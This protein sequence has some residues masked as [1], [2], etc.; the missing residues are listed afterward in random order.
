MRIKIYKLKKIDVCTCAAFAPQIF[1]FF[2][3]SLPPPYPKHNTNKCKFKKRKG[4]KKEISR[5]S[6]AGMRLAT[7]RRRHLPQ[8]HTPSVE[9]VHTENRKD[10]GEKMYQNDA[11]Y[12]LCPFETHA[13][14]TH[15]HKRNFTT[16]TKKRWG[17]CTSVHISL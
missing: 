16:Q 14:T 2:L 11:I 12:R 1:Y 4:E 13:Y 10:A 15:S 17:K 5:R 9:H 6:I 8:P 7:T 3:L